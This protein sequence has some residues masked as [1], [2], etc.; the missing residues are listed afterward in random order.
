LDIDLKSCDRGIEYRD[1]TDVQGTVGAAHAITRHGVGHAAEHGIRMFGLRFGLG[2]VQSRIGGR[3]FGLVPGL[4]LQS[5]PGAFGTSL[6][7]PA[8][9]EQQHRDQTREPRDVPFHAGGEAHGL[10]FSS[11][12][13]GSGR[14]RESGSRG[15][16]GSP[17]RSPR[18]LLDSPKVPPA[19]P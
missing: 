17:D 1:Q 19:S 15:V 8:D 13:S 11:P 16:A 6:I 12:R 7:Q 18:H 10:L 4:A 3:Q 2:N 5:G 9:R 14:S